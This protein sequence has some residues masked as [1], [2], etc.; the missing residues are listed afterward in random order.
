MSFVFTTTNSWWKLLME[1]R[2]LSN[3]MDLKV[4]NPR[5]S[6]SASPPSMEAGG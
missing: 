6:G 1:A 3:G 4:Y 5:S 2:D